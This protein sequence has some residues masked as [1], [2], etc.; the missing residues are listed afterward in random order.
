GA[1]AVAKGWV[2]R[3]PAAPPTPQ[4]HHPGDHTREDSD[5]DPACQYPAVFTSEKARR[6]GPPFFRAAAYC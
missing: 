2:A 3:S 1:G 5:C 6:L 4:R